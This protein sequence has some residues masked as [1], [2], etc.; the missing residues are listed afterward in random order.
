MRISTGTRVTSLQ[1]ATAVCE[2]YHDVASE[3]W[4]GAMW[5]PALLAVQTLAFRT[6][7]AL[8]PLTT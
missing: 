4:A 3:S 2:P 6:L 8:L 5:A 7:Y 1:V